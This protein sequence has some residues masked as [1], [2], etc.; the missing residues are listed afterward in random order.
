MELKPDGCLSGTPNGP[1][2]ERAELLRSRSSRE[3]AG[4]ELTGQHDLYIAVVVTVMFLA[5]CVLVVVN[6]YQRSRERKRWE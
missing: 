5:G 3:E 4:G 1:T 6:R 2:V